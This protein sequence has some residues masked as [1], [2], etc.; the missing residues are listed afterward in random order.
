MKPRKIHNCNSLEK[1]LYRLELESKKL[2]EK[3]EGNIEYLQKNY[4]SMFMNSISCK[5]NRH[6]EHKNGFFDSFF[7]N[8][9]FNATVNKI[10]DHIA[11]RAAEGIE[12]LL[13]KIFHKKNKDHN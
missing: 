4:T 10:T 2:E 9:S 6:E 11:N 7:K 1:E 12:D 3:L 5:S 13:D 8:D